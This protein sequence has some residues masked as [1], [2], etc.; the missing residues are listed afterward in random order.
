VLGPEHEYSIVNDELEALPI[1]DK[2]I[3]DFHGRI[4]NFVEQPSFTF[5][6]ELQLHVMEIK[7][8]E[9]FKSPATFEETMY[10]AVLTMCDFLKSKYKASLLGIGMHPLLKLGETGVWPHRDRKLYQAMDKV[11][12]LKQHGW[13]NIQGFQLNLPYH[14]EKEGVLLHNYLANVCTYLPAIAASSPIYEGHFGKDVDNRLHFYALNQKETPSIT[15]DVVPEY[16][17]SFGQYRKEVIGKYSLE[18]ARIGADSVIMNKEWINS[19]GV[20]FRFDRRA[21]EIRV[22]DEQECVKSDVALSCFIRALARGL[23]A[24]K[25]EFLSH[26]VLVKDYNAI[27]KDGLDARVQHLYGST[28]REVCKRFLLV[29]RE[30]A[31]DEEKKYMLLIEKRVQR[32]S[33]SDVIRERV[34]S[35]SQKT[36]FGEAVVGVY[37][38]LIRSLIDNEPYF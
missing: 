36:D 8:N 11:F 32:G 16:A 21:L 33:L 30:H 27:V 5:G 14:N 7:P 22:M 38:K 37:S 10:Q 28:A 17:S 31:T 26:E 25:A 1:V 18:L 34:K 6:K 29:A 9:P 12:N 24:E 20:I 15:G 13:L 35:R 4:V 23:M 3:K 2:V 19:R